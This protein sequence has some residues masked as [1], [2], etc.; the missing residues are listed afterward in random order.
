MSIDEIFK[1][2]KEIENGKTIE[3]V[4]NENNIWP[5]RL[6]AYLL[7]YGGPK[8]KKIL[9]SEIL[10]ELPISM[11]EINLKFQNGN[12]ATDIAKEI[13]VGT[14]WL[15][16]TILKYEMISGDKIQKRKGLNLKKR[17]N[18]L[19]DSKIIEEYRNGRNLKEIAD[20]YNAST[21]TIRRRIDEY[22]KRTG[23]DIDEEHIIAKQKKKL[24]GKDENK[25]NRDKAKEQEEKIK[26][27]AEIIKKHGY[28]YEQLCEIAKEKEY[29]E[30]PKIIYYQAL[31]F[32]NEERN[33]EQK[34]EEK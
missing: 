20:G 34:G 27:V 6:R 28:S 16:D 12:T 4:A 13:A 18:D 10:G 11:S 32:Q 5:E 26:L 14:E 7:Q 22:K 19:D 24:R 21:T 1:Y 3:E 29:D 17:R 15:L 2:I 25:E 9:L 30:I 8:G 23:E 31:N 33:E